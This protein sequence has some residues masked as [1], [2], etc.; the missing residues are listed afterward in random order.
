MRERQQRQGAPLSLLATDFHASVLA[1]L[2]QPSTH[3]L[4]CMPYGYTHSGH[5]HRS[6][7][8]FNG[9]LW[10]PVT[11][12]YLLGNGYR[13]FDCRLMRFRSADNLS[14]FDE[15][16]VNAYAYCSGDPVNLVDPSGHL[17][18]L[19]KPKT[20]QVLAPIAFEGDYQILYKGR[21]GVTPTAFHKAVFKSGNAAFVTHGSAYMT[22][23]LLDQ[24]GQKVSATK[25][26][27]SEIAPRLEALPAY[28]DNRNKPIY[29][30]ACLAAKTGAAQKVANEL[31]R[32]VIAFNGLLAPFSAN[33]L[34]LYPID[35]SMKE[36]PYPKLGRPR[37]KPEP[38]WFYPSKS[39][40]ND[41]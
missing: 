28:R 1:N 12:I 13:G 32:P 41:P 25:V 29:L 23:K 5:Q 37:H 7:T 36:A 6:L 18:S 2:Q 15:G 31:G 16:G 19:S 9:Q 4:A 34:N 24:N 20:T 17:P 39:V 27:R 11:D 33:L 21:E 35:A 38:V 8:G 22:S 40:R 10:E 3:A 26:A 14:P 30:I